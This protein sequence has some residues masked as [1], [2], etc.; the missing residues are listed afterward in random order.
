[1]EYLKKLYD[2]NFL[3]YASYVIKDRAIP[4]IND[5]FKPVQR[6]I[7]HSLW[8]NDD[9][10]FNK[11][12]NIVGHC[13]KYHPHGDASIYEALVNLA[14]KDY[15]ID[16]QG[17]FGNILTGDVASAA[18]YIECRLSKLA[19]EV[20]FNPKITQYIDSYDG[21]NLEPVTLPAKVPV[22]LMLGVEGIAV[23]MS[24]KILP[25]NFVELLQAQIKILK[26]EDFQIYPDFQ[27]GGILD[28]TEYL[29]GNGKVKVRAVMETQKQSKNIIIR[30]IPFGTT[31][32]SLL[33]SIED[34]AKK[35]KIKI[36]SIN[37]YTGEK[38]EI[39]IEPA[40]GVSAEETIKG[41]YAFT[42]CQ[43]SI[44]VNAILIKDNKPVTMSVKDILRYNT[45]MLVDMLKRELQIKLGELEDMLHY[46]TLEQIFI[47]NRIYKQI[48]ECKT[49]E[50]VISAVRNGLNK[51]KH[52]FIREV[53][54]ED[55]EKLLQIQIKRISRYDIDKARKDMDD[56]VRDI[57]KTKANLKSIT[58]YTISFI[59]DLIKKYG[60]QYPRRTRIGTVETIDKN[61]AALENVKVCYDRE[62]GYLGT[63]VKSDDFI[64]TTN[65]AKILVLGKKG[66]YR[67]INVPEKEFVDRD[68]LYFSA[69]DVKGDSPKP[70]FSVVYKNQTNKCCYIKKFVVDKF[71][72]AK[73]YRYFNEPG[74]LEFI[75]TDIDVNIEV[76]YVK[77]KG[78][79]KPT[80]I[81]K[82]KDVLVKNP[83]AVGNKLSNKEIAKVKK[84]K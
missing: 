18:R 2:G 38:V 82:F 64:V 54:D 75:T 31:T 84:V 17:N 15:F 49:Y 83:G 79:K 59:S 66:S 77:I 23:G 76:E 40:R 3:E 4:H 70:V 37:D 50:L 11:V 41:L 60:D 71:I 5:G 22:L 9:G 55:I 28:V 78:L 6:R 14:Q 72:T 67:V 69:I 12:A 45:E 27:Q 26:K 34:A 35:N 25:H 47:E 10:K 36:S 39:Q 81:F 61:E 24:T 63:D 20:L 52:L 1:M 51:F 44:S 29:E 21:R 46:K 30:E 8:E 56:I 65:Y 73:E 7:M 80:E 57:K 42:D 43:N 19:K 68:L 13:M 48:E 33:A 58:Q 53:T 62:T 74:K 32:E 16:K